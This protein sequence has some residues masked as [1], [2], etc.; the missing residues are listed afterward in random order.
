LHH[1][2]AKV[3]MV[4][5]KLMA[6]FEIFFGRFDLVQRSAAE[7]APD[8]TNTSSNRRLQTVSCLLLCKQ[9]YQVSESA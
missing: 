2:G 9:I 4:G 6:F 1:D 7:I 8:G 5:L 3:A